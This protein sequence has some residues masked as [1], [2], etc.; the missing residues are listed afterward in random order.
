MFATPVSLINTF[1]SVMHDTVAPYMHSDA[2]LYFY[3]TEGEAE[4]ARRTLCIQDM[5]SAAVSYAVL[6]GAPIVPMHQ[7]ILRIRYA[8]WIENGGQYKL[9]IKSVDAVADEDCVRMLT[10]AGRPNTF[11]TGAE[12][13]SARLYPI[14]QNDGSLTLAVYRVPLVPLAAD[15]TFEIPYQYRS[16]LLEWMRYRAYMKEDAETYDPQKGQQAQDTFGYLID[17]YE[18]AESK[19]RGGPQSGGISYGGL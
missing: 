7:S 17:G 19:R 12:T 8:W 2:E 3:M 9:D 10:Q 5:S 4:V 11:M 6:A 18:T 1:R 15:G 13:N 14:P 16:A